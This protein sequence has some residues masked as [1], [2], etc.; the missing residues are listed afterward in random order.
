MVGIYFY[1]NGLKI[2][3]VSENRHTALQAMQ[4]RTDS[5]RDYKIWHPDA[6]PEQ[7]YEWYTK[8]N[9]PFFEIKEIEVW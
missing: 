4:N 6:T 1:E 3:A 8:T 5:G 2:K 7:W 9:Y